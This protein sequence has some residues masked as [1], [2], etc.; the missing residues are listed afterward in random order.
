MARGFS[1]LVFSVFWGLCALI[2]G[3][4]LSRIYWDEW[5]MTPYVGVFSLLFSIPLLH[6]V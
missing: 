5:I 4:P 6:A 1:L 2:V 3:T